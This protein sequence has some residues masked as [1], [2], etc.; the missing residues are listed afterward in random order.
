MHDIAIRPEI[1]ER[2]VKRRGRVRLFERLDPARTA[3]VYIDM[4]VTFLAP[5]APVEV[6]MARAIVP[7]IN[8]LNA[9]LRALGVPS[10]GSPMPIRAAT[11][12]PI[13]RASSTISSPTTHGS[14][15]SPASRRAQT[16]NSSGP[17]WRSSTT[18]RCSSRIA[19]AR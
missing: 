2:V 9:R 4:Q 5:G 8:A 7:Q 3:A 17:N 6:P 11:G 12:H 18:T 13:G 19:T 1:V 10:T 14:A 16:A 15:P